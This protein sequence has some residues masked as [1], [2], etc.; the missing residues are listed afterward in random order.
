[1]ETPPREEDGAATGSLAKEEEMNRQAVTSSNLRSVG[2][3]PVT[4]TLE[5][6]FHGGP[7]YQYSNV[8]ESV[9]GGLMAAAS[10]GSYFHE[11]IRDQYPYRRSV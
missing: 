10:H 3:D 5:I 9:Y 2:Y 8:P 11:H 4:H 6:E 1:M 7:V